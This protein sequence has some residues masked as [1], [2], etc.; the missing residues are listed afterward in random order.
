MPHVSVD[1][2]QVGQVLD[3]PIANASGIV[4]VRAGT[5]LTAALIE[6]LRDLGFT[7]VPVKPPTDASGLTEAERA[8]LDTRFR[9]HSDNPLMM[10]I[11]A[12]LMGGQLEA[13]GGG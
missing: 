4:L 10:H 3:Q 1:E 13:A 8:A 7:H 11:K 12:L 5:A 9:G 2:V 6:R